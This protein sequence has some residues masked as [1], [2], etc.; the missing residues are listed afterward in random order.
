MAADVRDVRTGATGFVAGRLIDVTPVP[1]PGTMLLCAPGL[2]V[3][4]RR[5]RGRGRQRS[6]KSLQAVQAE[7]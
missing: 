2:V 1:E 5:V 3:I 6:R 7:V 4:A